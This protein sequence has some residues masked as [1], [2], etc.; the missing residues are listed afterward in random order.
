MKCQPRDYNYRPTSVVTPVKI[1]Y[2]ATSISLSNA[3]EKKGGALCS[4]LS[5]GGCDLQEYF[6]TRI[7]TNISTC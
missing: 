5:P 6:K 3:L 4:L 2:F 1:S 7:L